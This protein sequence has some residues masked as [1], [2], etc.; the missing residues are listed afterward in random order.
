MRECSTNFILLDQDTSSVMQEA[1]SQLEENH[2]SL[3]SFGNVDGATSVDELYEDDG[4][5]KYTN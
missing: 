5:G 1:L 3:I 2:V 4:S